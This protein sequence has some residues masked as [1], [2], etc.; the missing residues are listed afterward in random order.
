MAKDEKTKLDH[1][2]VINGRAVTL[3]MVLS[4]SSSDD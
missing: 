4:P 2:T 1:A 3:D